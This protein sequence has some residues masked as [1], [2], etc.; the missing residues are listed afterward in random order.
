M[1]SVCFVEKLTPINWFLKILPSVRQ[2]RFEHI[3][4]IDAS[5]W[6]LRLAQAMSRRY[7][8]S[9]EKLAFRLVEVKDENKLLLRLR[10]SFDDIGQIRNAIY[11]LPRFESLMSNI[12]T[13]DLLQFYFSKSLTAFECNANSNLWQA[14]LL[15]QISAWKMRRLGKEKTP[16]TLFLYRRPWMEVMR[17]YGATELVEIKTLFSSLGMNFRGGALSH[18]LRLGRI[19]AWH[20]KKIPGKGWKWPK[21]KQEELSPRVLLECYYHLNLDRPELFSDLA[22]WQESSLSGNDILV[23]FHIHKEPLDRIK[24]DQM[25]AHGMTPIVLDPRATTI[26]D[27]PPFFPTRIFS[28]GPRSLPKKARSGFLG[29][30]KKWL[31]ASWSHFKRRK[32]YWRNLFEKKGV[33]V[34]VTWNRYDANHCI[35]AN[36]LKDVGGVLAV[37]QRALDTRSSTEL[38]IVS[39]VCFGFSALAAEVEKGFGS[40]IPYFVV[41]GFLGDH[42]IPLLKTA[43]DQV[44]EKL[45][46][47]GARQIIAYTD[48]NSCGDSRW[49]TGHEFMRENYVFL[50]EKL[51]STPELGLVLK[52]KVPSTLRQRLGNVA[53]LLKKAEQTGR[54]Y[55]FEEGTAH[56]HYPPAIAALAADVAI[57]GHLCASTAGLECALTKTP[58][59]LLDREG[60]SVSPLYDLGVGKVVFNDWTSLWKVFQEHQKNNDGVPGFGD[61]SSMLDRF[62][63]FRDGKAS[64]RMGTYIQWL[65]EGFKHGLP[66]D[67]VL[68]DAAERYAKQWGADKIIS[69]S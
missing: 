15:I 38:A 47:A 58:T 24:L 20:F 36:A 28:M 59:L 52:P 6:V 60:W 53:E 19:A 4:V 3:F 26:R 48:E 37:Y 23:S 9:I 55:I 41:T 51:L 35:I 10:I 27:C 46:T 44:R 7:G 64:H 68:S 45:Q 65:I 12:E 40:T 61:W 49:H 30:E 16:R 22:F 66:R 18:W 14:L 32:H 33:K 29:L 5:P 67:T 69:I 11:R 42:R 1:N 34:F 8:L 21:R 39:D 25:K 63:P 2:K 62:D 17:E 50:L 13:D 54:C 56:G 57:H 43:A 31:D